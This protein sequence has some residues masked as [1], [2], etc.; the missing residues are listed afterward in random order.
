MPLLYLE[1]S[2]MYK[3]MKPSKLQIGEDVFT[4]DTKPQLQNVRINAETFGK[5]AGIL[6]LERNEK[7]AKWQ[8]GSSDAV[9]KFID[10]IVEKLDTDGLVNLSIVDTTTTGAETPKETPKSET[11]KSN[12]P[13][14]KA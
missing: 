3:R 7:D 9:S 13:K 12:T 2:E 1:Y 10:Q 4:A 14:A 6:G 8:R 5:L 11:P